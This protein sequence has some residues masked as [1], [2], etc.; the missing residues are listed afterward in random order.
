MET[1]DILLEK[2]T[3]AVNL[4]IKIVKKQNEAL[5]NFKLE[6]AIFLNLRKEKILEL[7]KNIDIELERSLLT[8]K[9]YPKNTEDLIKNINFIFNELINI[10]KENETLLNNIIALKKGDYIDNYKKYRK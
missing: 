2:K 3:K 6:K 10:E 1:L 8:K 9:K 4:I 5:K 7:M